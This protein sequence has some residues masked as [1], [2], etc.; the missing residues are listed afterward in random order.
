MLSSQVCFIKAPLNR[1]A[2]LTFPWPSWKPMFLMKWVTYEL[3]LVT[4]TIITEP[5]TVAATV[6][7]GK[8]EY[9]EN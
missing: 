4:E 1:E 5:A 2:F 8:Q 7:Q 6:T 3:T 9:L